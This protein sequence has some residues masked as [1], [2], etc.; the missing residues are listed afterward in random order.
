MEIGPP[1]RVPGW[2]VMFSA[3]GALPVAGSGGSVALLKNV[4][5][6]SAWWRR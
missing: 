6:F 2:C 3:F 4:F 1:T 5:A